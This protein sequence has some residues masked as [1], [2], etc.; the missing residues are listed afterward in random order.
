MISPIAVRLR[1]WGPVSRGDARALLSAVLKRVYPE[2]RD[3]GRILSVQ[4]NPCHTAGFTGDV[5]EI[6]R[7]VQVIAVRTDG[8]PLP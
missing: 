7:P 8:T 2:E 3:T 6:V 1:S 5:G 4:V